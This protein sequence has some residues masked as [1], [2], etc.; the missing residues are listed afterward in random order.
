MYST[1]KPAAAKR[2]VPPKPNPAPVTPATTTTT[3]T[4]NALPPYSYPPPPTQMYSAPP[5]SSTPQQYYPP[6][7]VA[8]AA[9]AGSSSSMATPGEQHDEGGS[10]VHSMAK[11]FG[12]NVANAAVWGFGA[13]GK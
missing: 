11:K 10:K 13:T 3:T 9:P 4:N 1:P 5:E 12:G 2:A 8:T 7:P 6:P